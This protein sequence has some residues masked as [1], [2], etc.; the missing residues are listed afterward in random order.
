MVPYGGYRPG[1]V[2]INLGRAGGITLGGGGFPM[3]PTTYGYNTST[4]TPLG[5]MPNSSVIINPSVPLNNGFIGAP[6]LMPGYGYGMPGMYNP[7]VN[8]G[9]PGMGGIALPGV[10]RRF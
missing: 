7:G 6:G 4:F 8:I 1:G 3:Y 9:V 2:N 10:G 5:G